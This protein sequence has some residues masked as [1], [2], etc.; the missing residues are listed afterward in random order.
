MIGWVYLSEEFHDNLV[1]LADLVDDL[2]GTGQV[3]RWLL[4]INVS[5]DAVS[6]I[7]WLL[8]D[9]RFVVKEVETERRSMRS[10]WLQFDDFVAKEPVLLVDLT[11]LRSNVDVMS[12]IELE[13][14]AWDKPEA[15]TGCSAGPESTTIEA[16]AWLFIILSEAFE[17]V[18][19]IACSRSRSILLIIFFRPVWLLVAANACSH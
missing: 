2:E 5:L 12:A 14:E 6:K 4:T 15:G 1:L 8:F 16:R 7:S 10:V 19:V 11:L 17:V 18:D 3:G 13:V 9:N